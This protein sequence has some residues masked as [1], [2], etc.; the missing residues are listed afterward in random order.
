MSAKA[1]PTTIGI[2]V[3]GAVVLAIVVVLVFGSGTFFSEKE[4]YVVFFSDSVNGLSVGAPVKMRGVKIGEV[5]SIRALFDEDGE[6]HIEVVIES[7][8]NVVEA[9]GTFLEHA[10]QK[11]SLDYLVESR[12]LRAQLALQS[13][14]LG[15]LYVNIDYFPNT[16]AVFTH[17]NDRYYEVPSIPQSG[18]IQGDIAR[19]VDTIVDL[20]LEETMVQ[21]N[22]VLAHADTAIMGV[23]LAALAAQ[24]RSTLEEMEQL[25]ET[26]DARLEPTTESLRETSESA[27]ATL[28]RAD[29]LF[30][31][32]IEISGER[33]DEVAITLRELRDAARAFTELSDYLQRHPSSII[34]GKD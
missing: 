30:T 27:R 25:T 31:Q 33:D 5:K 3:I 16:R 11:E 12:G 2:F 29:T 8:V 22:R 13:L 26:L 21:L 15:Q 32:L 34:W 1:N 9:T 4:R 7:L 19:L 14:V 20:P 28:A 10:G 18:A 17:L 24:A 23:D 6:V